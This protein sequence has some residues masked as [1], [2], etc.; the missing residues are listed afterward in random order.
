MSDPNRLLQ[1]GATSFEHQLLTAG[2]TDRPTRE[3]QARLLVSLGVAGATTTATISAG[4]AGATGALSTATKAW[5]LKSLCALALTAAVGAA[6]VHV[7]GSSAEGRPSAVSAVGTLPAGAEPRAVGAVTS[8]VQ[9]TPLPPAASLVV[10][11]KPAGRSPPIPSTRRVVVAAPAGASQEPSRPASSSSL[12]E[13]TAALDAARTAL[14]GARATEAIGLLDDF[15]RRF[16]SGLLQPEASAVRVEALLALGDR[17]SAETVAHALVAA[18]PNT[19]AAHR[20]K[21][22]LNW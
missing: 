19:F 18:A 15:A 13:E 22:M 2:L 3:A 5:A 16:S 14:R 8:A 21:A 9:T 4:G 11:A 6:T 10:P 17:G 7:V 12:S 20:V 1:E